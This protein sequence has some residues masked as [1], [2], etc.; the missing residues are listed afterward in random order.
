VYSAKPVA[1]RSV[2]SY[3][4]AWPYTCEVSERSAH[5][6]R[7]HSLTHLLPPGVVDRMLH[8]AHVR[9][10]RR[11][12]AREIQEGTRQWRCPAPGFGIGF[13]LPP[14]VA[15]DLVGPQDLIS[16]ISLLQKSKRTQLRVRAR[17]L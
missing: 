11:A 4:Q 1:G 5:R 8:A 13:R 9:R 15:L 7:T 6:A 12:R 3:R 14:F 17:T 16:I 10:H 2:P